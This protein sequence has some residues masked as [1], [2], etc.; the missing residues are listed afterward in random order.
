MTGAHWR[1]PAGLHS[2]S[3]R[4]PDEGELPSLEGATGW[5]NSPPLTVAGLR[6]KVVLVNF[7]TY[8]CVNWLRQLPYVRAWAGKYAGQGLVV[9]GVHTP[10]FPFEK[11][12]DNV[13][14]AVQDMNIGYP[15][16]TDNDYAVWQAFDN[17]YWPALYFADARGRI[18][19]HHFGEGEYG[20]SEMV[21]QQLLA[22]AG[23]GG[24]DMRLVSVNPG[25]VEAPADWSTL[26]SPE[27]Y[28]GYERT[29]NFAPR[30]GPCQAG[31][32]TT[33]SP[34]GCH[35]TSGP[36]RGTGRWRI[37]APR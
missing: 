5:L 2:A 24:E 10:E 17:H 11:D 12:V 27:N 13:R 23:S 28:T 21:I 37:R 29:E 20:R 14:R 26:R 1:V 15:V 25:G 33:S 35:S 22:E 8:T 4:L 3:V 34:T 9:I 19:H 36:C 31:R 32:T 16:A 30:A 7:W 18:R 6:G